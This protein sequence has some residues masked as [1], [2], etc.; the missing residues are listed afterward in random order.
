MR[1]SRTFRPG[2]L[3]LLTR[4]TSIHQIDPSAVARHGAAAESP[5][6]ASVSRLT[7]SVRRDGEGLPSSPSAARQLVRIWA[8]ALAINP[9]GHKGVTVAA[10][11]IDLQ[12]SCRRKDGRPHV[13]C[14]HRPSTPTHRP[15]SAQR[16]TRRLVRRS[17]S[18]GVPG[19]GPTRPHRAVRTRRRHCDLHRRQLAFEPKEA[20]RQ[21]LLSRDVRH[22]V[23][24][25]VAAGLRRARWSA[26][27][28]VSGVR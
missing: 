27:G 25:P 16:F 3:V 23:E 21:G 12:W 2:R 28:P 9:T 13:G 7:A 1:R 5:V 14:G 22:L 6:K 4:S 19:G 24:E 8:D 10:S 18:D 26:P 17:A 15:A 11:A 20:I